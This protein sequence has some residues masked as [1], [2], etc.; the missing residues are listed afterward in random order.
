MKNNTIDSNLLSA[1]IAIDNTLENDV[2]KAALA[3]YGYGD[4]KMLAGKALLDNALLLH[5]N[6][7]KEYGDQYAATATLDTMLFNA[8]KTY[9]NHVKIARIALNGHRGH[10][11]ALQLNGIRKKSYSG[12]IKQTNIFYANALGDDAIKTALATFGIDEVTLLLG[13]TAVKEVETL[14]AKQLKEKG[15]AQEA[16]QIRDAAF[17]ELQDWISDFIAV[18]R[19]ALENQAQYLEAL[20]I[21]KR[22]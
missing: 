15:E 8:N 21:V 3:A 1:Q 16:T 22:A 9:M 14:L 6:Q 13:Q 19:I 2:I 11:E 17:D 4:A 12:W 10:W 5:S 7:K 20:G 18:A